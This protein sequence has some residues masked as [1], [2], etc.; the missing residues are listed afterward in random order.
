MIFFSVPSPGIGGCAGLAFCR[1][2]AFDL[3][4]SMTV[5]MVTVAAACSVALALRTEAEG[6][7]LGSRYYLVAGEHRLCPCELLVFIE[8]DRR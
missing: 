3:L 1:G 8:I 5:L 2:L 6:M 7:W 4:M